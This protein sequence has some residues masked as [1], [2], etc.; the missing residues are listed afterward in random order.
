MDNSKYRS[1][2][3]I[4]YEMMRDAIISGEFAPGSRIVID[5]LALQYGISHSPIR[6]CLRLLEGDGFVTIRPYAGVTV[7][8][9]HP[10][11]IMEVFA[12]LETLEIISSCRASHRA[13]AKQ[14][15][16]LARMINE[17]EQYADSPEL[18]SA[19]NIELH[20]TICDIADMT[21]T[22]NMIVRTLHHWNRL[23]HYYLEEVSSRR[24]PQAQQEHR[25]LLEAIQADDEKRIEKVIQQHNKA[26][27]DDYLKHIKDTQKVDLSDVY[28]YG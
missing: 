27:L 20:M 9:I 6:E 26:A 16:L 1:K 18:W 2:N 19:K 8:E 17:M 22:K 3:Q 21:I 15:T 25:E 13:N 28:P 4:V 12:L 23:R 7:T 24:I 11:F 10:E 5:D 14:L